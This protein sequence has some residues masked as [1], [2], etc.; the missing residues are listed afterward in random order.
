LQGSDFATNNDGGKQIGRKFVPL[1]PSE[2]ISDCVIHSLKATSVIISTTLGR[3]LE[4]PFLAEPTVMHQLISTNMVHLL[5][6][7]QPGSKLHMGSM[8]PTEAQWDTKWNIVSM[9][10]FFLKHDNHLMITLFSIVPNSPN[11][12]SRPQFVACAA[13]FQDLKNDPNAKQMENNPVQWVY[14]GRFILSHVRGKVKSIQ[15]ASDSSHSKSLLIV[16]KKRDHTRVYLFSLESIL[17]N[18]MAKSKLFQKKEPLDISLFGMPLSSWAKDVAHCSF[19]K[20]SHN[21]LCRSLETK[22]ACTCFPNFHGPSCAETKCL[23]DCKGSCTSSGQCRCD[24]NQ[25]GEQC[26][27]V[28]VPASQVLETQP[29]N[30]AYDN[31]DAEIYIPSDN[32]PAV[33]IGTTKSKR[34]DGGL[35]MWDLES[36]K[37]LEFVPVPNGAGVNSVSVLYNVEC[38]NQPTMDMAIS[39]IRGSINGL[40]FWY[41]HF[42]IY[43]GVRCAEIQ[44]GRTLDGPSPRVAVRIALIYCGLLL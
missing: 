16:T 22:A 21:G 24:A 23:P 43:L 5:K 41:P 29:P 34:G 2:Q 36:G 37:E 19:T 38:S 25:L 39:S 35:H 33:V 12:D 40:A 18:L 6:T 42:C 32:A 3:I 31:D 1:A 26:D 27:I 28:H 11:E 44:F 9:T 13:E 7:Q 10:Q 30:L 20:C 4:I 17:K 14:V 15:M 8:Q